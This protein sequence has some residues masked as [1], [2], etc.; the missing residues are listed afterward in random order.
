MKRSGKLPSQ[1]CA[2]VATSREIAQAGA[3]SANAD[4]VVG[5]IIAEAMEKVGKRV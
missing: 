1:P 3:I 5:E 4:A 2:T